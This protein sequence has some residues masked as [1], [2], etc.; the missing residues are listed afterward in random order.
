MTQKA[1]ESTGGRD[2]WDRRYAENRVWSKGANQF[3]V[4]MTATLPPGRALDLGTGEGRNA[5]WL[6]ERDWTVTGVDFSAVGVGRAREDARQRGVYVHWLVADVLEYS[7][8][9]MAY[10]LVLVL[11]LHLPQAQLQEVFRSA[12]GA[13]AAG[14]H[15]LVVGHDRENLERGYGGPK[16][17]GILYSQDMML[18]AFPGL[19]VDR[20]EQVPREVEAEGQQHTAIDALVW[21]YRD[22]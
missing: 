16:D 13:V 17:P 22:R 14:G 11:Y 3:L 20:N 7:P 6:A 12:A 5:I 19:V 1:G 9:P 8:D 21:A 10:D 4:E 15:L 18:D 2:A